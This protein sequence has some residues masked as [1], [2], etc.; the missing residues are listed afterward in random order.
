[1]IQLRGHGI[2]GVPR[3]L[4]LPCAFPRERALGYC[5]DPR[6]Y[7]YSI[8]LAKTNDEFASLSMT[9]TGLV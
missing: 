1:L 6:W 2:L 4:F 7:V 3:A 9:Q 5:S 8:A